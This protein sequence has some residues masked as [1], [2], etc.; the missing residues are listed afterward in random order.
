MAGALTVARDLGRTP[1][2]EGAPPVSSILLTAF[3]V[4]AARLLGERVSLLQAEMAGMSLAAHLLPLDTPAAARSFFH[5]HRPSAGVLIESDVWP[6][7]LHE[8]K[9]QG[10]PMALL[11]GRLSARSLRRWTSL[12]PG[13]GRDA[14]SSFS[15]VSAQTKG[16][17]E[18]LSRLGAKDVRL[19]P[20]LKFAASQRSR[21]QKAPLCQALRSSILSRPTWIA[22]STH[23][24]E[25]RVAAEAHR[26]VMTQAGLRTAL[27]LLVPRHPERV[28]SILCDVE[29]HKTAL[30]SR[31]AGAVPP[32]VSVFLVDTLGEL[33]QFYPLSRVAFIGNSL[34]RGGQG[35][36]FCEAAAAGVPCV[37][38]PRLGGYASLKDDVLR[39][40]HVDPQALQQ[41][42]DA[43]ELALAVSGALQNPA[44]TRAL[45]GAFKSGVASLG[46]EAMDRMRRSVG[47]MLRQQ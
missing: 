11:D 40:G 22:A 39:A 36:N 13:V 25:E 33:E 27:L 42:A 46:A 45:G 17:A 47:S 28:A 8:A 6:T 3:S 12:A 34:A 10:V 9:A 4:P 38:G 18:R 7:F 19:V 2:P 1:R 14:F 29:P 41:V 31:T 43:S 5:F 21:A 30:R 23:A 26:R 35:H 16:D 44:E 15:R 32:G 24:G 37:H 20:S